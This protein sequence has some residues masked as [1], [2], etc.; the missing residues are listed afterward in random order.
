MPRQLVDL[1]CEIFFFHSVL[2][3]INPDL[4][5]LFLWTTGILILQ[6]CRLKGWLGKDPVYIGISRRRVYANDT[7]LA[8]IGFGT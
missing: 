1:L 5:F 2:E 6:T 4:C 7:R 8:C 3:V